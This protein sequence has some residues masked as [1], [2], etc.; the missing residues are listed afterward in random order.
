MPT[1]LEVRWFR[2]GTPPSSLRDW[3]QA[4]EPEPPDTWTDT[5]LLTEDPGVNLK[6]REDQLQIK[7]RTAGPAN[8]SFTTSVAGRVERWTKWSF[9]LATARLDPLEQERGDLWIQVQKT[10][11]QREF[12]AADL[13]AM[14]INVGT[15]LDAAVFVELTTV[16]ALER[17]AW[18]LC[19]EVE[20]PNEHL[21]DTFA[22]SSRSL[23][24]S[25]FPISLSMQESFGYVRWLKQH[26]DV[27][28]APEERISLP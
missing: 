13:Q 20:G 1:T 5:Y 12:D 9:D 25:E 10:R 26:P 7:R 17:P 19:L 21:E 23:L 18:T 16:A 28:T 3:L 4:L 22:A 8:R 14:G 6:I 24:Q 27:E 15:D 11:Q 2:H